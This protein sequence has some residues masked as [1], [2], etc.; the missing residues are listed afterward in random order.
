MQAS[1]QTRIALAALAFPLAGLL[2]GCE[3][4]NGRDFLDLSGIAGSDRS[5]FRCDN[6]RLFRVNYNDD[7]D[8]AVIDAGDATYRLDLRDRDGSRRVYE[9][10]QAELVVNGND[11]RLQIS[12]D[13]DYDDCEKT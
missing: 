8:E 11:A 3:G 10:D 4:N 1:P 2:A 9:G 13:K 7:G 5:T 12:G 6:D